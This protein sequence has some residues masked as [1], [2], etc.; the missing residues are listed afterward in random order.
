[1]GRYTCCVRLVLANYPK[2][3]SEN[4]IKK[5]EQSVG[6]NIAGYGGQAKSLAEVD[7]SLNSAFSGAPPESILDGVRKDC[8]ELSEIKMLIPSAILPIS[9]QGQYQYPESFSVTPDVQYRVTISAAI[10]PENKGAPDRKPDWHFRFQVYCGGNKVLEFPR[11]GK[12]QVNASNW[13]MSI[14]DSEPVTF[15]A[16]EVR[17]LIAVE[18][19]QAAPNEHGP[20]VFHN[21]SLGIIRSVLP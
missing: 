12:F 8:R 3:V 13:K 1:M 18:H 6:I 16:K 9:E 2:E 20:L 4:N 17:C 14:Q 7:K 19:V 15:K 10:E 21:L 5:F 11:G